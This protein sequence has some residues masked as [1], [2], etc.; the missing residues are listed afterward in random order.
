MNQYSRLR[1]AVMVLTLCDPFFPGGEG[2]LLIN[3]S[4]SFLRI[5]SHRMVIS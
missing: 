2:V 1:N 5:S 4:V 3:G